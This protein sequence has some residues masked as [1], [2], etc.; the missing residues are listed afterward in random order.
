ME[1]IFIVENNI[2]DWRFIKKA[3]NK[4]ETFPKDE[5]EFNL[6]IGSLATV[7]DEDTLMDVVDQNRKKVVDM[8]TD[9][10]ADIFVVDYQLD[11]ND[12][13]NGTTF[14]EDYLDR[15]KALII[16]GIKD[17]TT[18]NDIYEFRDKHKTGNIVHVLKK[19]KPFDAKFDD[20]LKEKVEEIIK[21]Q[22]P[23]DPTSAAK[24]F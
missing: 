12:L 23:I 3:L 13:C 1:K 18:E 15:K 9:S 10:G 17:A 8:I 20:R 6:L 22:W 21:Q 5:A 24:L 16:T 19:Q 2:K 11:S 7:Y 14:I 4:Y